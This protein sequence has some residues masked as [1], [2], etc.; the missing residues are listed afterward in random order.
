MLDP[1]HGYI[2][3][4]FANYNHSSRR[5]NGASCKENPSRM[6]C[7]SNRK[8]ERRNRSLLEQ[9]T[10]GAATPQPGGMAYSTVWGLGWRAWH[11]PDVPAEMGSTS[12]QGP[13]QA[14]EQLL[15]HL[16]RPLST[17]ALAMTTATQRSF[18]GPPI[19]FER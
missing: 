13:D 12:D 14:V 3:A 11:N 5:N 15:H 17:Q 4:V 19:Y 10:S 2:K 6:D 18:S 8:L 16:Q 1:L 9:P 7:S